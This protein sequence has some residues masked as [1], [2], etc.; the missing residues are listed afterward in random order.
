MLRNVA[1]DSLL[2]DLNT[3]YKRKSKRVITFSHSN[4]CILFYVKA[5]L[6]M[7]SIA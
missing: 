5:M 7:F 1:D 6:F 4:N 2:E 3:S